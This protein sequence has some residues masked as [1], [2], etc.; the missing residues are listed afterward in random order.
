MTDRIPLSC[1]KGE[2]YD[3]S[4]DIP[5]NRSSSPTLGNI[6]HTRYGRRDVLKGAL[7]T[8]AISAILGPHKPW[9]TLWLT[10]RVLI[11]KRSLTVSTRP[12]M[13]RRAIRP[14]S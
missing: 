4:E 9:P 10:N 3:R 1:H 12:I 14:I 13:S 11:L 8:T 6:I 2:A 5:V 7:A